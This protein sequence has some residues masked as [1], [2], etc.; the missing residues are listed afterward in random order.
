MGARR[1]TVRERRSRRERR[2]KSERD[3]WRCKE[4]EEDETINPRGCEPCA[5]DRRGG[6]PPPLS[7]PSP[8]RGPH[9]CTRSPAE[10]LPVAAPLACQNLAEFR[11]EQTAAARPPRLGTL[12]GSGSAGRTGDRSEPGV[13][14]PELS[15]PER[16]STAGAQRSGHHCRA[17]ALRSR[18]CG[19]KRFPS[20]RGLYKQE[21]G[22]SCVD[23]MIA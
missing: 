2:T 9:H 23:A 10:S 21:V 6:P 3:A 4:R 13:R 12:S 19:G 11:S 15:L 16:G 14:S 7:P 1:K 20:P 8:L 17:G 18:T 22:N 5:Q